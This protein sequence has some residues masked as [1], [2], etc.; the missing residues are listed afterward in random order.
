MTHIPIG[1]ALAGRAAT[2]TAADL[3]SVS[4][5][6]Y[7]PVTPI[8][9]ATLTSLDQALGRLEEPGCTVYLVNNNAFPLSLAELASLG[10]T[11]FASNVA[12]E[13]IEGHGNLG[14]GRGHNVAIQRTAARYH[15]ILNP[16]VDLAPD[17]LVLALAFLQGHADVGLLAPRV[18][19]ED[20]ALQFLCR[21]PPAL[22]D[23][24]I[25][26]FLP[27]SLRRYFTARLARY[28]MRDVIGVRDVVY[29]PPILSGCF[30]LFDTAILH[31]IDGFDPRYFLYFE[32]YDLSLRA[33][34]ITRS[35]YVPEVKIVH[36]GGNASRKGWRHI[37]MFVASAFKFFMRFGWR[38]I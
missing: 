36:F 16:D 2:D 11:A 19:G 21:R 24:L 13:L 18:V 7:G 4:I 14:Y 3:L 23:L 29:D 9:A 27:A 10:F 31:A 38:L 25:R 26:G 20:G 30:M 1:E 22:A 28:E 37:K 8:L 34:K 33:T 35:A 17:S 32:D 12:M 5:V 6:I 15:L